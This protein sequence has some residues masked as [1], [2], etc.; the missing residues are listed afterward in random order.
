[1]LWDKEYREAVA[2]L[3][4]F[5]KTAFCVTPDNPRALPGD[6]LAEEFAGHGVAARAAGLEEGLRLAKEEAGEDGTMLVCGSLYLAGP[7]RQRL[8]QAEEEI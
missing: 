6:A 3:A 7:A 1:M 5:V 2:A 4:P 8:L